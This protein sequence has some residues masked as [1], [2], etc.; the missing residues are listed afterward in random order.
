MLYKFP[1][2]QLKS[3][4][5]KIERKVLIMKQEFLGSGMKF[6]IQINKATG[7]FMI[8][9]E[10]ESIRESIY[11]ILM[12]QKTERFARSGFGSRILSYTFTDMTSTWMTMMSR[13]IQEDIMTQEPRIADVAIEMEPQAEEGCLLVS[14]EYII[15][16]KNTKDNL[17]FPFY[18]Q[19][20][21]EGEEINGI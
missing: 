20:V 15:I 16:D 10:K 12:T 3:A 7:R 21:R 17:V 1:V 11:L 13:E 9:S 5:L 4:N 2:H 14:I 18:L 19:A 8:S 6:P